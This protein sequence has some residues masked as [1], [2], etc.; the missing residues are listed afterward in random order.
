MITER[1]TTLR[2]RRVRFKNGGTIEML[3]PKT[4]DVAARLR[5]SAVQ[6]EDGNPKEIVGY[7]LV[8]WRSSGEVFTAYHNGNRSPILA[9][10]VP[11]YVKDCLLAEVAV[12]WSRD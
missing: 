12:R 1:T 4:E 8:V 6:A 9:G 11:Q 2:C 5:T 10:Q 7:A 3:R